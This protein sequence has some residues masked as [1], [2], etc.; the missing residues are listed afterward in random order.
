[1]IEVLSIV[2]AIIIKVICVI[3]VMDVSRVIKVIRVSDV[4]RVIKIVRAK[5]WMMPQGANPA[6]KTT[7][8]MIYIRFKYI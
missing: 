2:S 4:I 7:K 6:C 3:R 5:K 8:R 1:M